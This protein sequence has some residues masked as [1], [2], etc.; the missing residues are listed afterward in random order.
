MAK[1]CYE[2]VKQIYIDVAKC[3]FNTCKWQNI[4]KKLTNNMRENLG[5]MSNNVK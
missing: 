1:P 3:K 2:N 5:K 4:V